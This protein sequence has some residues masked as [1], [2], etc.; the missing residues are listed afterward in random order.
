MYFCRLNFV[1][2]GFGTK[3]NKLTS[4][5]DRI[6]YFVRWPW[7]KDLLMTFIATTFSIVLTFGTAALIDKKQKEESKRQ[8]VMYVLYDLNRSI[9][10]VE[11]VDSMLREGLE[12]QIEVAR[13]TSTFEQKRF[14]FNHCMPNEHFDNT[15][16][17]IFSS[18][19]ETL[20]TLDN[21]RFVEMIST[22]YHDRDFYES[23]IIDS[24]RNEFLQKSHCWD[25]QTA[26]EFPY[27]TYIFMS[28]L[29]G[30]SLK[31]DFQQ[32]KE[33][34][35]VSDEEFAAFELQKQRQ[36]VSNTSADNKKDKFVKELLE[37]DARLESAIEE[38]KGGGRQS[39]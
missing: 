28:G 37:N 24:C 7:L 38:G 19:F 26:L 34:M 21:V 14:F 13:D 30:E 3:N 5:T 22:F 32:C 15:T 10:L 25:L 36:S 23:M 35:G 8:M 33:L 16:A 29:V 39:E 4:N 12:L 18:N 20:N 27:S 1:F 11:H 9:E 17:Q 31:E 6:S 2:M